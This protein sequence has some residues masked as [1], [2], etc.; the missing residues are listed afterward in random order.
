MSGLNALLRW[1]LQR[2][3]VALSDR[4]A[5]A[6]QT[7]GLLPALAVMLKRLVWA[8]AEVRDELQKNG[9][10]VIPANFYSNIPS[11]KEVRGSFEYAAASPPYLD[12][13]IFDDG[14]MLDIL[15]KLMPYAA[16]F[17]PSQDGDE[18]DPVGFF[19]KNSQFS[20]SDA[21]SYYAMIRHLRPHRVYSKWAAGFR[22]WRPVRR[23][24]ATVAARSSASNLIRDLSSTGFP[25][26]G[27]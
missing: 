14:L 25:A 24:R 12:A 9:V 4:S 23:W 10:N 19:W 8:P 13:S 1:R 5:E 22:P 2:M 20:H 15:A 27:N 6:L 16:E 17:D 3:L 18:N 26:C 7:M 11:I 21:M